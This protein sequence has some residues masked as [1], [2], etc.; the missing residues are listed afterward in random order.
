MMMLLVIMYDV[1][2]DA[3]EDYGDG[4][5]DD[6]DGDYEIDDGICS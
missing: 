4:D 6:G 5:H 1:Y 2:D 3:E